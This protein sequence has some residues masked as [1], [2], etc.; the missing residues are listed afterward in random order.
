MISSSLVLLLAV[1]S[2]IDSYELTQP[3]SLTV[4]PDATL[5]INCKVS[6]SVTDYSTA[7]IRQPAGKALE[8]I[9]V[10]WH[11]GSLYY[12]DSLKSK[13]SISR[14][15]SS[16]TITLQGKNMQAEDTAVYYCFGPSV[17]IAPCD[18]SNANQINPERLFSIYVLLIGSEVLHHH[19]QDEE[20]TLLTAALI[21]PTTG[22]S[23]NDGN[24]SF[25]GR[26]EIT[27][28]NSKSMVY[29][30]LSGLTA[31]DSAVYYCARDSQ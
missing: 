29:L 1:I 15:T 12:K 19:F 24:D 25:K 7:W 3:E 13:F 31:E 11:S 26:T 9:G 30:K 28:D 17:M 16:N 10:I 20:C 22:G 6:Y 4:R 8:W 2:C 14:D 18:P 23:G 21:Q 5:T 27:R